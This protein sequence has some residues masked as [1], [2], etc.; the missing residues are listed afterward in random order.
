MSEE[1]DVDVKELP[2]CPFT[3]EECVHESRISD[4]WCNCCLMGDLIREIRLLS[5]RG[6]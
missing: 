4:A 2:E 6:Q 3:G 5:I 1:I